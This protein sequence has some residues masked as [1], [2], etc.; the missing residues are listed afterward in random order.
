MS[1]Q[2]IVDLAMQCGTVWAGLENLALHKDRKGV[3]IFFA[4]EH[5]AQEFSFYAQDWLHDE[6][7]SCKITRN[8]DFVLIW[9]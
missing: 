6:G 3:A 7:Y 2:R 9:L 8:E 1:E 4:D 5:D